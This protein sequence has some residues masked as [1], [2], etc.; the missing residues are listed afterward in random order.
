MASLPEESNVEEPYNM[1]NEQSLVRNL[2][3]HQIVS[4]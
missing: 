4:H 1:Y 2:Y 3:Y